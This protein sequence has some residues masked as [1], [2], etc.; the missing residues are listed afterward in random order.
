VVGGLT[1]DP[2]DTAAAVAFWAFLYGYVESER[3]GL[4][5]ASGPKG[6]FEVGLEALIESFWAR[7]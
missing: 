2:D 4:F 5:G 7:G 6:G 3:S 1:G